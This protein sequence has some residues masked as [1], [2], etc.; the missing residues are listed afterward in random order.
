MG[1]GT[2]S[3]VNSSECLS[4]MRTSLSPNICLPPLGPTANDAALRPGLQLLIGSTLSTGLTVAV[5]ATWPPRATRLLRIR[6]TMTTLSVRGLRTSV[7]VKAHKSHSQKHSISRDCFS[8]C[9]GPSTS[10]RPPRMLSS[11][12]RRACLRANTGKLQN[13]S[14]WHIS[15]PLYEKVYLSIHAAGRILANEFYPRYQS[16]RMSGIPLFPFSG[17]ASS[18]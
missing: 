1:T 13:T 15:R 9:F 17:L 3:R 18:I 6:G 8:W 4:M 10:K 2:L 5:S 7:K 16:A 14:D 11:Q 12:T